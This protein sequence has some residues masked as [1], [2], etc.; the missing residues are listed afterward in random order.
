MDHN[1]F[2]HLILQFAA[3]LLFALVFGQIMRRF[4]QPVI[5][6]ELLGGILL[7]PTVFGSL[8]PDSFNWFFPTDKS[9]SLARDAVINLGMLFFLFVA[10][11]EVKLA[12]INRRKK[13][14]VLTSFL[15]WLF[16]MGLGIAAVQ[17]FPGVWGIA[18]SNHG[19]AF[20]IFVGTALSISAKQRFSS[21]H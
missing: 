10:G 4:N 20:S 18:A 12:H 11:L 2:I 5:L 17:L 13:Q 7:G 3:M 8:A 6:G 15:G 9:L 21:T 14:I 16:P 1:G 19:W